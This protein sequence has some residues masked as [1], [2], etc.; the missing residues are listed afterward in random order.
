[1]N[2]NRWNRRQVLSAGA[3]LTTL[4]AFGFAADASAAQ[5][6]TMLTKVIPSSGEK[7]PVIGLGTYNV[8]DVASSPAEIALKSDI[9]ARLT[10]HGGRVI[11]TS[12][13]YRR[14]EKVL[15]DVIDASD[16]RD[17]LFLATKV[18]TDGRAP[19]IAQ[20]RRSATLMN[21]DVID[22][23]Q[24][25]NL[26]D[27]AL[28]MASIRE[29]QQEGFIRYNGLTHYT[30]SSHSALEKAMREFKPDFIQINYSLGEREADARVLPL[31]QELGIA[32]LINRPF[33]TGRL[34]GAVSG[35]SVPDWAQ[36]FAASWGQFFLKF[37]V[38]HPAVT[39]AI[40]ATSKVHHMIDNMMAGRGKLPDVATR[41]RMIHYFS[42]L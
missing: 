9:V 8:F 27:T 34:F 3:L 7:L 24:V 14:S 30:A 2:N 40:P 20:M 38:S 42:S 12:P 26:R 39:V 25:H 35:K 18:W 31:A 37:I 11:D 22:L 13:M 23:M 21:T 6:D 41:E 15:G 19:G 32:V 5:A 29:M 28:H 36:S 16:D 4:P 1:M 33:L 10:G 17:K